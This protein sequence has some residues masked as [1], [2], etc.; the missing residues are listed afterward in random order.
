MEEVLFKSEQRE[1]RT[2]IADHLRTIA[3]RLDDGGSITLS[4]GNESVTLD[5]PAR[6]TFE[7]KAE[8]ET[9]DG[10]PELSVEFEI[11]WTEGENGG[12]TTSGLSIE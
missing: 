2:A 3:D 10:A 11:E 9:G 8:R 5:V 4:G 1:T 6:A 7:V 12:E